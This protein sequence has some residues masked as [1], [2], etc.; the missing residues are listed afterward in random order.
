MELSAY[1]G[2]FSLII[3]FILV[4]FFWIKFSWFYIFISVFF[5]LGNWLKV[6]IH[7][8]FDYDYIEPIGNFSGSDEDWISFYKMACVMGAALLYT[9]C[10]DLVLPISHRV[11]KVP[12]FGG[13][14]GG[15]GW[16]EWFTILCIAGLF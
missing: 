2:M 14:G 7:H 1:Y 16:G 8:I 12:F 10:V 13:G 15:V 3:F 9:R 4:S 5:V 11:N 6:S